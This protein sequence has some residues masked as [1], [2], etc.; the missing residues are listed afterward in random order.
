MLYNMRGEEI[1]PSFCSHS[2][3]SDVYLNNHFIGELRKRLQF[4]PWRGGLV[5]QFGH[6]FNEGPTVTWRRFDAPSSSTV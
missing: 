4:V 5:D 3:L 6:L 2:A 1:R